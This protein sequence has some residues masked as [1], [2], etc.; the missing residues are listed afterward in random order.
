MISNIGK[1]HIS[2]TAGKTNADIARAN[3]S[4]I[5]GHYEH[6]KRLRQQRKVIYFLLYSPLFNRDISPP[7]PSPNSTKLI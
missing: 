3:G 7:P 5:S 6:L 4:D 1:S 2:S